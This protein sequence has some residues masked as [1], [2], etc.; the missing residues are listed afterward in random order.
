M[1]DW[2]LRLSKRVDIWTLVIL[3]A[4][5]I[6][7]GIFAFITYSTASS[8]DLYLETQSALEKGLRGFFYL[9]AVSI[10]FTLLFLGD[11]KIA[12]KKARD[13]K[14][15][16][17][18]TPP[19]LNFKKLNYVRIV[20]IVVIIF[21]SLPWIFA[22]L[23][24]FISDVPG[25]NL[26]FLGRQ[27]FGPKGLPSVHLGTHHGTWAFEL[28][29]IAIIL[30]KS[31]DS[32][33]Y[34]KDIRVRALTTGTVFFLACF[35]IINGLEDGL[36]EQVMKRGIDLITYDIVSFLYSNEFVSYTILVIIALIIMI[37]W[38]RTASKKDRIIT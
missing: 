26:I 8:F 19:S 37:L 27:G 7:N 1:Y 11:R 23:G 13:Q 9:A 30:T 31:L 12:T 34:L 6:F 25:L 28:A 36:N 20:S 22:I 10:P 24:I 33:Y 21:F 18:F 17:D 3:W 16:G 2:N 15:S 5:P 14:L 32:P 38:Y 35:T 29:V 4:I